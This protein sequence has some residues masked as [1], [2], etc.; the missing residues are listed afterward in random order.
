MTR[1]DMH[2]KAMVRHL[3]ATQYV[4]LHDAGAPADGAT[5]PELAGATTY[6]GRPQP[7]THRWARH[8]RDVMTTTVVTVGLLTPYKE[9]ARAMAD[10]GVSGFPVLDV[11]DHV[12]GVV[13][14]ANLLAEEEKRAWERM[15]VPGHGLRP[16]QHWALTAGELM[17]SPAITIGPD[18]TIASAARA[19]NEHRVRRLPVVD[20]GGRLLGIVSRRDLLS[21][22]LRTDSAEAAEVRE[23]FDEVLQAGS[24]TVTV[25]VQDGVVVI[26]GPVDDDRGLVAVAIRLAWGVDGVI[27]VIDHRGARRGGT[28]PAGAQPVPATPESS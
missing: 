22:F 24:G 16:Q 10:N 21:V 8:V 23:V 17:S 12:A 18:A 2:L 20:P 3:G 26:T 15:A 13:S 1:T 9:V 4:S 7:R 14:E 28:E 27:D 19:M 11:G 25:T 5:A 6:D